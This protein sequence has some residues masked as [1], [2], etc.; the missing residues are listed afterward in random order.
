MFTGIVSAVGTIRS[1]RNDADVRRVLFEY[2]ASDETPA[3]GASIACAGV[4]LTVVEVS[5][6]A[7]LRQVS[8]DIG[9]E[10]LSL[11]TAARWREG[12]HI[13]LERP[14]TLADELGGHLVSGHVDGLAEIVAR[15]EFGETVAFRF[16]APDELAKFIAVKGSVALDGTSLTVNRVDGAFFDCHMIPHTLAATTW[17]E[18]RGGDIVNLEV[19]LIARYA[20]RMMS[21]R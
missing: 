11:T 4:C 12:T 7:G 16:R 3:I 17:A 1:V 6:S 10:T 20:E 8:V 15:D 19:D 9:P 5:E 2:R 13:N 18:R 21:Y 14:L